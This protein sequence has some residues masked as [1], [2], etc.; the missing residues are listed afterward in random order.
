MNAEQYQRVGQLY[1]AALDLPPE[2][3]SPFL[4]GRL[5]R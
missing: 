4:D 2:S 3:R 5:R 1:H